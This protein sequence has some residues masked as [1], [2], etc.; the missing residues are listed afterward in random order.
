VVHIARKSNNFRNVLHI[1]RKSNDFRNVVHIARKKQKLQK[2][3][4]HSK[5]KAIIYIYIYI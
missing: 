4:P 1:A 2:C 3:G 5:K